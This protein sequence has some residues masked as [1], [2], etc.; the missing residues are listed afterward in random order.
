MHFK[1]KNKT[2]RALQKDEDAWSVSKIARA[3]R[4]CDKHSRKRQRFSC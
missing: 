2:H 4:K 3:L 1:R